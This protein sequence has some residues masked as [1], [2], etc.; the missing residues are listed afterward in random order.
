[1]AIPITIEKL[2]NENV[3]EF[4]RIEFKENFNPDSIIRTISAF[5]NDIDNWGGGYIVI[6]IK[7]ENGKISKPIKGLNV[8]EI[9]KIQKDLLRYSKLISSSY[10]PIV[11]VVKYEKAHLLL[12]WCPGGN[13]RPYKTFKKITSKN[14]DKTYFIR[15]FSSTIEANEG[16]I[17]ELNSL[18]SLVP[19]DAVSI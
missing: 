9:D 11:E 14:S 2:L 3:D 6:G 18:S 16:D 10:L 15:K 8:D 13:D 7:E 19:F 1:M 12:I 4:A 17:K 5:A